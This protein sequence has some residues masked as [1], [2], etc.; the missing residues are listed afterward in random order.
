MQ[1]GRAQ[2]FIVANGVDGYQI[3]TMES[4]RLTGGRFRSTLRLIERTGPLQDMV[5][6]GTPTLCDLVVVAARGHE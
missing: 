2:T 6:K 3:A 4:T 1:K 5:H